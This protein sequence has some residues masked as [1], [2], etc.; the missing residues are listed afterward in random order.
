MNII[1]YCSFL[2]IK[3]EF[4][5]NLMVLLNMQISG[6]IRKAQIT[7]FMNQCLHLQQAAW[8]KLK[9]LRA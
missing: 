8:Q 2:M 6:Q 7:K 5:F 1:A 9:I 4:F 3:N